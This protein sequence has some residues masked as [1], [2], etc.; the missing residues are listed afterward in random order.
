VNPGALSNLWIAP[1]GPDA[2]DRS[3][4][5]LTTERQAH[6]MLEH[7]AQMAPMLVLAG[8]MAGWTAEAVSRAGGY[9]LIPDMVLG[10]IGSVL[11]GGIA[12][13][14]SREAGM[15]GMFVIGGAG[16]A[17]AVVAQRSLWRS[18]RLGA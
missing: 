11:V 7:I 17:L 1:V 14:V 12:S 15:L 18:I 6:V 16:A 3:N 2:P 13:A 10:L 5:K 8:L 4:G 9:G